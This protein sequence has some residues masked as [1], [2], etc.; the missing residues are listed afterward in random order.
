MEI[1]VEGISLP[2]LSKYPLFLIVY[3]EKEPFSFS[4]YIYCIKGKI[5]VI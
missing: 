5:S 2:F 3:D 4:I 1:M